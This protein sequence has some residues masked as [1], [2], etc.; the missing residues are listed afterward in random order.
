MS[1]CSWWFDPLLFKRKTFFLKPGTF[2]LSVPPLNAAIVG[3]DSRVLVSSMV[4]LNC[5]IAKGT[6]A[7]LF[8]W[9]HNASV[10]TSAS[11]G[12]TLLNNNYTLQFTVSDKTFSGNYVCTAINSYFMPVGN[13]STLSTSNTSSPFGLTVQGM[14]DNWEKWFISSS[15]S[16][17]VNLFKRVFV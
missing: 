9:S 13:Y 2:P 12:F 8:A 1:T 15:F 16:F 14:I 10:I 4:E 3:S 17:H 11:P 7:N 5:S 6:M